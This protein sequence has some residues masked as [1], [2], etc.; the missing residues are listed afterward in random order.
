[1]RD[2]VGSQILWYATRGAGV[3]SLVLLTAVVVLGVT[4]AMR[5]QSP[6]WPRFVT[7]GIH[8]NLALMAL[9][10]L[11]IHIVTAIVDPFTNLGLAALVPFAS[12]Y[13]TFW[14]GLGAV[15]LYLLI[16]ILLTSLL[17]PLFGARAWRAVH[18]LAY[19][20]WPIA[21]IHGLGTGSDR[22]FSWMLA[23]DGVCLIAVAMAVLWRTS[24]QEG[25]IWRQPAGAG[26]LG[27]S[28]NR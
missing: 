11:A 1:M 14:L 21:W 13:R 2:G 15:A 27:R 19:A 18:W 28:P 4:S 7:T 24:R 6:S 25:S 22:R 12:A 23:V 10:F 8:R 26:K 3:V 16:A 5:A 20:M 9:I 17:R